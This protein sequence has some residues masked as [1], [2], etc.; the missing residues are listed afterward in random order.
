LQFLEKELS[1]KR[2]KDP[3]L[4]FEKPTSLFPALV[5]AAPTD[6]DGDN[7]VPV[8]EDPSAAKWSL[9]AF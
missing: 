1:R 3:A 6:E 8:S 9:W 7:N 2:K 5:E 4:A